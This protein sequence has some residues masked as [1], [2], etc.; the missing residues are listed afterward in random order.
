MSDE[1]ENAR[2]RA[3]ERLYGL[4]DLQKETERQFGDRN[5][6]IFVFGSY[7][8]TK[9]ESG[10]S[11]ID[12]AVYTEDFELYKKLALYL[13]T[14]F[15]EKGILTDIFYIDISM[16]APVYCAPLSSKVQ[17]T[18]YYPGILVDFEKKCR[19]KLEETKARM[20]G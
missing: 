14:Y 2:R 3:L 16:A 9:Y 19:M 15:D 18:D 4:L 12:I 13:E 17:F 1:R 11:D 20:A 6:N 5:Y 10:R 7:L 8:T